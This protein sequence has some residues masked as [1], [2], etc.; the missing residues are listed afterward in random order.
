MVARRAARAPASPRSSSAAGGGSSSSSDRGASDAPGPPCPAATG[1]SS[2]SEGGA[3]DAPVQPC[4]VAAALD[5]LLD[6]AASDQPEGP[7]Q[8]EEECERLLE[9]LRAACSA[10]KAAA[11][12]APLTLQ[13]QLLRLAQ[14]LA[15][16]GSEPEVSARPVSQ[17]APGCVPAACDFCSQAAALEPCMPTHMPPTT[18]PG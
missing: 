6:L 13:P 18:A 5:A 17:S 7:T 11:S 3:S 12:N 2:S 10:W 9:A 16:T 1:S 8:H 4:P 15:S 14:H